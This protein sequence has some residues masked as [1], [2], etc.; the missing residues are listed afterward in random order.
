MEDVGARIVIDPGASLETLTG[1]TD[2]VTRLNAA[3]V[4]LGVT[5]E[6]TMAKVAKGADAGVAAGAKTSL[7]AED[8][9][10][11]GAGAAGAHTTALK[12]VATATEDVTSKTAKLKAGLVDI[13]SSPIGKIGRDSILGIIGIAGESIDQYIKYQKSFTQIVTQAGVAPSRLNAL[14]AGGLKIAQQTGVNF[15]DIANIAYR[16]AS[17]TS[18]LKESNKQMLA[19][20]KNAADL[21]VLFNLPTGAPTEQGARILGALYY[22]GKGGQLQGVGS[23]S[24][25]TALANAAVGAGDIR[26]QDLIGA[27]G[28]GILQSAEAVHAK[29][30]DVLAWIDL[31][32]KFGAQP[33]RV[34]TL[35]SHSI[36]Q[37]A[38]G[39]VQAGKVESMVGIQPNEMAKLIQ[40]KGIEPAF[41]DLANKLAKFNPL[42]YFPSTVVNGTR[43]AA[44]KASAEGVASTWNLASPSDLQKWFNGTASPALQ[45][46]IVQKL[47]AKQFGGARQEIPVLTAI[48]NLPQFKSTEALINKQANPKTYAQDLK[49]AM[50]TPSRQLDIAL[51]TLQVYSVELGKDLTPGLLK[52]VHGVV[53]AAQWLQSHKVVFDALAGVVG[54]FVGL[55]AAAF[56]AG[57]II[58]ITESIGKMFKTVGGLFGAGGATAEPMV[59]LTGAVEENTIAVAR[60]AGVMGVADAEGGLPRILGGKSVGYIPYQGEAAVAPATT[61]AAVTDAALLGGSSTGLLAKFGAMGLGSKLMLG[62]AIGGIASMLYQAVAQ[63]P[64]S[65]I[66]GQRGAAAVGD[67]INGAAVG[68]MVLPGIGTLVGAL[69]G[70]TFALRH[71]S[72]VTH[73]QKVLKHG[74][75]SLG[76]EILKDTGLTGLFHVAESFVSSPAGPKKTALQIAAGQTGALAGASLLM[77]GD[78]NALDK[79]GFLHGVNSSQYKQQLSYLMADMTKEYGAAT[80]LKLKN[81]DPNSIQGLIKEMEN[82]ALLKADD[83]SGTAWM[84]HSYA[85]AALSKLEANGGNLAFTKTEIS[86]TRST[87][88]HLK[89]EGGS[90]DHI[91]GVED[92]LKQQLAHEKSLEK[93]MQGV[94]RTNDIQKQTTTLVQ[95]LRAKDTVQNSLLSNILATLKTI[96]S[97]SGG[98]STSTS[99]MVPNTANRNTTGAGG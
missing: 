2:A 41:Q 96:N 76:D 53:G 18:G 25:L 99:G 51:R 15:T 67:T 43:L 86:G 71:T 23:M 61:D 19:L 69:T 14:M 1:V 58:K 84:K 49:I 11:V 10:L 12:K 27:L 30:P 82:S 16:V 39:T 89:A 80:G 50:D 68:T 17:A 81:M 8:V 20:V 72:F 7:A 9:A 55:S 75:A 40:T 38:G 63:K 73:V 42:S 29:L 33:S 37:L 74:G 4:K 98:S 88:A 5:S 64:F 35:V 3:L 6:A 28:S 95:A 34:G 92:Q 56:A 66:I 83:R 31:S 78:M 57:K 60:L 21:T 97:K 59:A 52:F 91:K 87:L 36:Q 45:S 13:S 48:E 77:K 65:R 22:A 62:G 46:E 32:T 70:L 85:E 47:L 93:D 79:A 94:S 90:L 54:A 26:G 44:G 24:H